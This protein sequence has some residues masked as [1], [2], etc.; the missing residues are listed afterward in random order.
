MRN[1]IY[2]YALFICI[3]VLSMALFSGCSKTLYSGK[4]SYIHDDSTV[5]LDISGGKATLDGVKC[6]VKENGDILEL[7]GDGGEYFEVGPS[8]TEGQ[9]ILYKYSEY[10]YQGEGN[11]ESLVGVWI[12]DE[13]WQFEFTDDGTFKEDGYF[14]GYYTD[15]VEG[16]N[17]KL[18]YND[19]FVDTVCGYVIDG[20]TLTVRYPW[21]MVSTISK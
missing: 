10:T 6:T 19:H 4:W 5:A 14:P 8:D 18:V 16:S 17:F 3:F 2:R 20:D 1:K 21:P 9:I 7:S 12:S 11:P 15:N 13:G